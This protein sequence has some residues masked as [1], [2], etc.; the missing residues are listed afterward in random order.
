M[1]SF[2]TAVF[3]TICAISAV[4]VARGGAVVAPPKYPGM[5]FEEVKEKV[6]GSC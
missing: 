4:V 5:S 6:S 2:A 3:E 1:K